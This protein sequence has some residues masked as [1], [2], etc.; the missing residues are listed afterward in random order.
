MKMTVLKVTG[1]P[2]ISENNFQLNRACKNFVR[3]V[4]NAQ[5]AVTFRV[6]SALAKLSV[7]TTDRKGY[8][9]KISF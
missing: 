6:S 5:C 7:S 2:K 9:Y 3:I 1:Y 8:S 4:V